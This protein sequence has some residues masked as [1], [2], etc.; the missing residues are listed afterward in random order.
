MEEKKPHENVRAVERALEILLAFRAGD[1]DLSVAELLTRV[2]LSRPTLYRLLNTLEQNG[3]LVSSGEPQ[4][5]RLGSSV[6]QLA[7]AWMTSNTI[8]QLAQPML[9]E[10][11][12]ATS[13][14]VALFVPEG[15]YRICVAELESPQP[16]SFRRGV[17]YREKLVL[18]ASGRTILSQMQLSTDDLQR[19]LTDPGQD[20]A[21]LAADLDA[22]RARGF[23]TSHHALIAGAV[24]VAAPF[25]NGANQVA[26]SVCIFG[27][28]VRVTDEQV[29]QFAELVKREAA[30]LSRA[31]GQHGETG[32]PGRSRG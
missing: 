27:P 12:E 8:A 17:G 11:W 20:V 26:G 16:L 10:L 6:A 9:R 25:F 23:G 14:T 3:F 5:F 1:K 22:V 29:A 32:R 2:D 28:S 30:K 18:G 4:R 21:Q 19:Y 15:T 31:L 13:E 24:A 7:H